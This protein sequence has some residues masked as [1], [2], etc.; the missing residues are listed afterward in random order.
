MRPEVHALLALLDPAPSE[1]SERRLV[2]RLRGRLRWDRLAVAAE[3]NACAPFLLFQLRRRELCDLVPAQVLERLRF[4]Y[5][6][7]ALRNGVLVRDVEQALGSLQERDIEALALDEAALVARSLYPDRGLR[8]VSRAAI[9][10]AGG[11]A[12]QAVE[13]LEHAGYRRLTSGETETVVVNERGTRI[14]LVT[15]PW[16]PGEA[17]M[18]LAAGLRSPLDYLAARF[19]Y[20]AQV[21]PAKAIRG[22]DRWFLNVALADQ[23]LR[24]LRVHVASRRLAEEFGERRFDAARSAVERRL[25]RFFPG[26]D[27]M[28]R[29]HGRRAVGL[30]L[31]TLYAG[32]LLS[33]Q[34][35]K[36]PAPRR[37]EPSA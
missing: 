12:E 21:E 19:T 28:V 7:T 14:Q 29:R 4:A 24:R 26:R 16:A 2:A 37:D 34:A 32:R 22:V 33:L 9:C 11:Q 15:E 3:R 30:G 13:A 10:V 18:T 23:G 5:E 1:L 6:T 20:L 31:Y 36:S 27:E 35:G 25:R 8:P 17:A